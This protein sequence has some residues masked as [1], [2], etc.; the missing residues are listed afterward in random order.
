[1]PPQGPPPP[2]PRPPPSAETEGPTSIFLSKEVLGG[3]KVREGDTG[4]FTVK[5]VDPETGDAEAIIEVGGH[6]MGEEN[7]TPGYEEAFDKAMPETEEESE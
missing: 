1:M 6:G 5:S 3:K 4:T 7:E 2:A